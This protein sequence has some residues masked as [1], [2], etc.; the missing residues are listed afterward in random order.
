MSNPGKTKNPKHWIDTEN[1]YWKFIDMFTKEIRAL[2]WKDEG[3]DRC[4][5]V[6]G[7]TSPGKGFPAGPLQ[8]APS[9]DF[10]GVLGCWEWVPLGCSAFSHGRWPLCCGAYPISPP[11]SIVQVPSS[12]VP[13][14]IC[15]QIPPSCLSN[16]LAKSFFIFLISVSAKIFSRLSHS[17]SHSFANSEACKTNDLKKNGNQSNS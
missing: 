6:V 10:A 1:M 11:F 8:T 4:R 13:N 16:S 15:Y 14:W 17:F 7:F 9:V 5:F 2:T 12:A 3:K